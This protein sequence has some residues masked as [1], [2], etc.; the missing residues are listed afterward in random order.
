MSYFSNFLDTTNNVYASLWSKY[1]PSILKMMIA[2]EAGPQQYKFYSHEFTALKA[3]QKTF[4][5]N[6]AVTSGKAANASKLHVVAKDLLLTLQYSPKAV[7][8]MGLHQFEFKLD[9]NFIFHVSRIAPA[10]V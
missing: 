6:V 10:E 5:F 7:E 3:N 9:R 8:L 1:R 4:A 2:A